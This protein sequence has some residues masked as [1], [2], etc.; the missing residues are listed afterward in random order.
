MAVKKKKSSAKK[1]GVGLG[2]VTAIAAGAY[3]L[4]GKRGEKNRKKVASWMDKAK[5]EILAEMARTD[6]MSRSNY[7]MIVD[8]VMSQYKTVD[9]TAVLKMIKEMKDHWNNISNEVKEMKKVA[10][11][12]PKKMVK[13]SPKK[14]TTKRKATK[15]K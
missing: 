14:R 12:T 1:L 9:K 2:I 13:K 4:S 10:T 7:N 15:K 5:R 8:E 11:K 3:L 6:K